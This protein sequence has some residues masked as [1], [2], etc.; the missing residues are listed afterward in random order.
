MRAISQLRPKPRK[1]VSCM[2]HQL[3]PSISS[4]AARKLMSQ[5][6]T[7]PAVVGAARRIPALPGRF[8]LLPSLISNANSFQS[9]YPS[10]CYNVLQGM[11]ETYSTW[12][13]SIRAALEASNGG[14]DQSPT[15]SSGNSSASYALQNGVHQNVQL[16]RVRAHS[17]CEALITYI[18][19]LSEDLKAYK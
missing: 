16:A 11:R 14:G 3:V 15:T 5:C 1:T 9:F 8:S 6:V 19:L 12:M 18:K 4:R 13:D 2:A 17:G 7:C 10:K